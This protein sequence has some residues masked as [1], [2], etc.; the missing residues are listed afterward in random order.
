MA[1]VTPL[2]IANQALDLLTEGAID[3]LEEDTKAARL[4][5]RHFDTTVE[6]ELRKHAWAFAIRRATVEG[7]DTG[8]GD[9]TLAY[10]Y[11]LPADAVRLLPVTYDG[12]PHGVPVTFRQEGASFLSDQASLTSVR[13]IANVQDPGDWDVL[14]T[15]AVVAALAMKMAHALTG[16]ASMIQVAQSAYDRAI[17]EARRANAI[18]QAGR[19]YRESWLLE[20]GDYRHWRP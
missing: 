13:Y 2:D 10:E 14:F 4:V 5:N 1:A 16:K 11:G 6:A 7:T 20:R 19:L 8:T 18:E 9:G 12:D 3:S 17:A 15:E